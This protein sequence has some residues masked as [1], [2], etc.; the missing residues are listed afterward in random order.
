MVERIA[1]DTCT[2]FIRAPMV[3]RWKVA[4]TNRLCFNC[5]NGGHSYK[6]CL[7]NRYRQC[8]RKHHELLHFTEQSV[9][10]ESDSQR[11]ENAESQKVVAEISVAK[12][13]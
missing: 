12:P 5:L 13:L 6:Q 8:G 2:D 10:K 7:E 4:R 3:Q 9:K 1:T 11:T